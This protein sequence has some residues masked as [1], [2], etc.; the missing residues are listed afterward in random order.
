MRI[1]PN[2]SVTPRLSVQRIGADGP[3]TAA[4][5]AAAAVTTVATAATLMRFRGHSGARASVRELFFALYFGHCECGPRSRGSFDLGG[6]HVLGLRKGYTLT[7]IMLLRHRMEIVLS[8]GARAGRHIFCRMRACC[9]FTPCARSAKKK[10]THCFDGKLPQLS[11]ARDVVDN[12]GDEDGDNRREGVEDRSLNSSK[13]IDMALARCNSAIE[14]YI[15]IGT[16]ERVFAS[17]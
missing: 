12:D 3:T 15:C 1:L 11:D 10:V 16:R 17:A 14:S 9:C 8:A 5:S 4:E 7:R 13:M 6:N 2:N